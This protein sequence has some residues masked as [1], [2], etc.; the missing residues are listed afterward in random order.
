MIPS[1]ENKK[2]LYLIKKQLYPKIKE[3][4]CCPISKQIHSLRKCLTIETE[5]KVLCPIVSFKRL[6]FWIW[7]GISAST[8]FIQRTKKI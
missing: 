8:T 1:Y 4:K 6:I 2:K 5:G 7:C 3:N